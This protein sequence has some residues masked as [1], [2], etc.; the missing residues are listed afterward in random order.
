MAISEP[1]N[2]FVFGIRLWSYSN[3]DLCFLIATDMKPFI[4]RLFLI[5][6]NRTL[7]LVSTAPANLYR[8]SNPGSL[9]KI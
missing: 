3:I 2:L 4:V 5:T 6:L 1:S 8:R 7:A 9:E